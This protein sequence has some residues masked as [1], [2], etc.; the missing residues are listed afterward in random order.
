MESKNPLVSVIMPCYNH[1]K[2]V[3]EA[4]ESVLNQTYD[5]FEFI[6]ADNG[7]TDNSYE[8]IQHYED[9]ITKI[10]Q[11]KKN[12]PLLCGESLRGLAKGKYI[13]LMTSDDYWEKEKLELQMQ[14][15][16]K[17]PEVK[18]CSTWTVQTDENLHPLSDK[19]NMFI[20]EN[21]S[22]YQWLKHFVFHGNCL[23]WPSVVIE[24]ELYKRID[25]RGYK[26][27]GDFYA[28]MQVVQEA[29]I[30]VVPQVLVKFRCHFN[31]NNRNESAPT[32]ETLNRDS[33][34]KIDIIENILD[35]IE[36][37]YFIKA[38][39]D[40]FI[41]S[42]AKSHEELLCEK[43]F[44][45]KNLAETALIYEACALNFYFRHFMEFHE[46]LEVKYHFSYADFHDWSGHVGVRAHCLKLVNCAREKQIR[47]AQVN[48]L[49]NLIFAN[50]TDYDDVIDLRKTLFQMVPQDD[51][52]LILEIRNVY[53]KVVKYMESDENEKLYYSLVAILESVIQKMDIVWTELEFIEFPISREDWGMYKELIGY[54][55]QGVI[56]LTESVLP[57]TKHIQEQLELVSQGE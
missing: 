15:F 13:A 30:Y 5:N 19:K 53:K 51:R 28:W 25:T 47:D 26:Q 18:V 37:S 8:V 48:G 33:N 1:E 50:V 45:L 10:I 22:R 16:A 14:V 55:K 43:F 21:R 4:I 23:A 41:Y 27:L 35:K 46:I 56:D 11:F 49:K 38:F 3:G 29:D 54:A 31:G 52:L 9:K 24:T 12:N 57:F 2:Y 40:I 32:E 6:V 34:E 7:S 36:D 44:L 17:H 20:V 42:D 39:Q